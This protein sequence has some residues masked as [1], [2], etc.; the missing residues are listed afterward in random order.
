LVAAETKLGLNEKLGLTG[1]LRAAVHDVETKLKQLDEPR[2]TSAMLMMRRHEK[3]F[4]LRRDQKYVGEL[5]KAVGEFSVALAM[6]S[7]PAETA[8]EITTKLDKY[9]RDFLAWAE[10]A[11][12]SHGLRQQHDE[13]VSWLRAGNGRDRAS[14]RKAVP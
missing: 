10:T 13:D 7:V 9:L 6:A 3:D 1:A 4:M 5:K 12:Q 8:E 11:Q 14:R 2:L